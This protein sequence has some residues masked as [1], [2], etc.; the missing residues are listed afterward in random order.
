[1]NFVGVTEHG[2]VHF[3]IEYPPYYSGNRGLSP[4]IKPAWPVLGGTFSPLFE[5]TVF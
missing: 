2:V 1:M 4:I 3:E 5:P